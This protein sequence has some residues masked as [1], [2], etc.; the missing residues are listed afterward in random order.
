[1]SMSSQCTAL[2]VCTCVGNGRAINVCT[3]LLCVPA[4][5][6]T[7]THARTHC[8]Q[9]RAIFSA[10]YAMTQPLRSAPAPPA[11]GGGNKMGLIP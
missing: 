9:T 1:M 11:S 5:H 6:P 8:P 4:L 7:H 3:H 2:C 10:D